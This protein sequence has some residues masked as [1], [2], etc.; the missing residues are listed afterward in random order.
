LP[1]LHQL[2]RATRAHTSQSGLG[3]PPA[4]TARLAPRDPMPGPSR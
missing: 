3:P 1:Q 2:G 4:A